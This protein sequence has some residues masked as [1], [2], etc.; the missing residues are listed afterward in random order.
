MPT[1]LRKGLYALYATAWCSGISFFVLKTWFVAAGEFGPLKHSW[2][3]PSLQLHGAAAFLM[4]LTFGYVLG[5]HVQHAWTN[6]RHKKSG[7][8][9]VASNALLMISAYLLYYI[10]QDEMRD[11]VEYTH[12][13]VGFS[14]PFT[15]FFHV[16]KSR[17][18]FSA[19]QF[20]KNVES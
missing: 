15:L 1:W 18:G 9:I 7:I 4:M 14:L 16:L 19:V 12:L 10:A 17:S 2:Q 8:A 13:L 3:F 6:E 11:I 5:A 20:S